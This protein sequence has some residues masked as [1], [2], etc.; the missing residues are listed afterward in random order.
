MTTQKILI[1]PD[2]QV[3]YQDERALGPVLAYAESERWDEVVQL[4]DF[5]DCDT[6]SRHDPDDLLSREGKRLAE[7][8]DAANNVLD[9]IL[10]AGRRK[11][12]SAR[13]TILKGNHE[14]RI[15][16]FVRK[17]PMLE[18][19]LDLS[20]A[21]ELAKRSVK[22]VE[23]WPSGAVHSI[24]KLNFTH[25]VYCGDN[26]AKK[27]VLGYGANIVYGHTHQVQAYTH[28]QHAHGG[29]ICAWSMGCLCLIPLP[30]LEGRPC[31]WQHAFGIAHVRKSGRFNL[32]VVNVVNG[33]FTAP[34]GRDFHPSK[35]R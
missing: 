32:A 22:L 3:P 11:N 33:W 31:N 7:E 13:C 17:H 23:C 10:K 12:R 2:L 16:R 8:F 15:E 5:V 19:M 26:H 18:G 1:L 30:Y 28:A 34:N 6:L 27:H 4:G 25:G 14:Y 24:G 29:P 20:K 35:A 21:L 9:R